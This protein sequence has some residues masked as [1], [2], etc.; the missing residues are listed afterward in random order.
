MKKNLLFLALLFWTSSASAAVPTWVSSLPLNQ[1]YSIPN[2]ALSSVAPSPVPPG[3]T[4]PSCKIDCWNGAAL[5]RSGSVYILGAAGGHNDY[6]GNEVN[7]ITLNATTPAW[8][9][10][11]ASTTNPTPTASNTTPQ[12][13]AKFYSD[14]TPASSHTYYSTQFIEARNRMFVVGISG[15][16]VGAIDPG[17]GYPYL[18]SEWS[19]SFNLSTNTWDPPAY[20]GLYTGG[21]D[22]TA[23]PTV[24]DPLTDDIYMA[25]NGSGK[26]W[27]WTQTTNTWAALSGP[28]GPGDNYGCAALDP[29]RGRIVVAGS[30][31]GNLNPRVYDLSGNLQTVTFTGLGPTVLRF[32][33]SYPGCTY[34]EVNNKYLFFNNEGGII[35]IYRVDPITFFVDQPAITGTKPTARTNGM[36]NSVQYVPELGGI[37]VANSYTGNV[38]FMKLSGTVV[39]T[40]VT[41]FTLTSPSSGTKPF[42]IGHAF[43]QGDV[44]SGQTVAS[45][46]AVSLQANIQN[47]W[48]DGSAK[49]AMISGRALLTA[50]VA[51]TISLTLASPPGGTDLTEA[52]LTS[53]GVTASIQFGGTCTVNLSSLIGATSTLSAG[54]MTPG[55]VRTFASGP[56]MSNWIYYSRCGSDPHLSVWF[57][58]RLYSS[59]EVEIVPWI[60]NSTLNIASPAAKNA[61]ATFVMAGTTRYTASLT[62]PH[63]SRAVLAS[64]TTLSH[65]SGTAPAVTPQHNIA[66]FQNTKMV[67]AYYATS[68]TAWGRVASTYTPQTQAQIPYL[69]NDMGGVGYGPFIGLIPEWE[70]AYITSNG[71]ARAYT[72]AIINAYAVGGQD[73]HFRD[74]LTNQPPKFSSFPNT[75]IGN[76]EGSAA[77]ASTNNTLTPTAADVSGRGWDNAHHPSIGY[78]C[79]LLTGRFWCLEESQFNATLQFLNQTDDLR[80]FTQGILRSDVGALTTRGSGWAIRTLAQASAIT[81]DGD[82]LATEFRASFA[83]NVAYYHTKY[84][85]QASNPLGIIHSYDDYN[86]GATPWIYSPWMED[87]TVAAWGFAIDIAPGLS[88]T[89]QA[90]LTQFFAWHAQ[91]TVGRLGGAASNQFYFADAAQYNLPLGPNASGSTDYTNGT[92]PWWANWAAA[93]KPGCSPGACVSVTPPA[94]PADGALRGGN[95]P[96][97]TSYWGNLQPAITYAV[98]Q[99]VSGAVAAYNR[100]IGASN[101]ASILSTWNSDPVWGVKPREVGVAPPVALLAPTNVAVGP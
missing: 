81:P 53:S 34:D 37:A 100:M 48:P 6:T 55:R 73:I 96:D 49:F 26:W 8:V 87:F 46:D 24:K 44:P 92:G 43:K 78:F 68:F 101:W 41:S 72:G 17:V 80:G 36:H 13:V 20:V 88:A 97:G 64:G 31:D 99:N 71:D 51:K 19:A 28:F 94:A 2:T 25:R 32:G 10:L 62:F 65:W 33:N 18:S 29:V 4:G 56:V 85:A 70:V 86:G 30:F 7:A 22:F 23:A 58:V 27:K 54:R 77:G 35:E 11:K 91:A 1:W 42:T 61:T 67:P 47:V 57:D 60:E 95:F 66:Y 21:G 15:N 14:L 63:H 45:T 5:K 83:S 16:S 89:N 75:V 98:N 9:Q 39:G 69:R 84:I 40:S 76:N 93:Y 90:K 3:S 82:A 59:G 52:N 79:Y 12:R 74:E 38:Q 50:N